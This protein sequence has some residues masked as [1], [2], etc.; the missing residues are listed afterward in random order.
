MTTRFAGA[1]RFASWGAGAARALLAGL[2]AAMVYGLAASLTPIPA[3]E[4][5][6]DDPMRQDTVL[7]QAVTGRVASGEGYYDAVVAEHRARRYP[8]RPFVTVRPPTLALVEAAIGIP[9]AGILLQGLAFATIL[10]LSLRFRQLHPVLVPVLAAAG[11]CPLADPAL[12]VWHEIWA[13]LL[14][15]L[16]LA[17]RAPGRWTASVVVAVLAVAIRELALPYLLAMAWLAYRDGRRREALAWL[18]GI[19]LVAVGLAAHAAAIASRISPADLLSP[20]W[21]SLGGLR[22]VVTMIHATSWLAVLSVPAWVAGAGLPLALLGWWSRREPASA[23]GALV[24]TGY[25]GAFLFVG[26][27]N[28]AY[29]GFLLAPLV[30]LGLAA[31]PAALRDLCRAAALPFALRE[32]EARRNS[33]ASLTPRR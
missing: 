30:F 9:A 19:A 17:L 11:I 15:A 10:A 23:R 3:A 16:S 20:G 4:F 13:G 5:Q 26:R 14:I 32:R 8:L 29:W 6:S 18:A 28:N 27:S 33:L 22:L 31:A 21:A 12:A 1:S 7:Y 25:V 2:A 24:V